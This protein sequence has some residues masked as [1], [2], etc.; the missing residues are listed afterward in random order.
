MLAADKG[1]VEVC[2][3]LAQLGANPD[4]A[5]RVSEM[6]GA[7]ERDSSFCCCFGCSQLGFTCAG[8]LVL[9]TI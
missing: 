9:V 2:A 4:L 5:E 1:H 7:L 8:P 3:K 6:W